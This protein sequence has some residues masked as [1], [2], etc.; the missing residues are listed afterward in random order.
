MQNICYNSEKKFVCI[1]LSIAP[2]SNV[3]LKNKNIKIITFFNNWFLYKT[4]SVKI[5]YYICQYITL[6]YFS[7]SIHALSFALIFNSIY[8]VQMLFFLLVLV[9][10]SYTEIKLYDGLKTFWGK[11]IN[12][13]IIVLIHKLCGIWFELSH[14]DLFSSLY[15][16]SLW[17]VTAAIKL[18]DACSLEE[19]LWKI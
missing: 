2:Y 4:I 19:K 11:G 17:M 10:E 3:C 1:T 9:I 14:S 13:F 5:W 15:L 8:L 12:Y 18:K 6:V 7:Y 16:K